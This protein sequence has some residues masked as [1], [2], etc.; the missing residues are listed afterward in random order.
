MGEYLI[1]FL[2]FWILCAFASGFIARRKNRDVTG[3]LLLG[4]VLGVFAV[5]MIGI[6]PRT[7]R[8]GLPYDLE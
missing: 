1:P 2:I 3:W 6:L 5:I 7:A 4:V 8:R